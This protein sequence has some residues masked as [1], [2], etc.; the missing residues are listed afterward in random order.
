MIKHT[1]T[2][3]IAP[4]ITEKGAYLAERGAYVFNVARDANKK[5]ITEAVRAVYKV[6]PRKIA[7]VTVPSKRVQT[8]GTNRT[9]HTSRGKKAYVYLKAG[10]TIELA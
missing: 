4:R 3:L 10:D 1:G 8:R 9:G 6:T 5:E 7:I 2:I